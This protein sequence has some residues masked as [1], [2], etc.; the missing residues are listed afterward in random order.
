[1]LQVLR[2]LIA[3]I[4]GTLHLF[5]TLYLKHISLHKEEVS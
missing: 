2:N 5:F 4:E 1:M 3:S